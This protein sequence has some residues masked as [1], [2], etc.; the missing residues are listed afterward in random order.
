M[1]QVLDDYSKLK[2]ISPASTRIFLLS[3]GEE[4]KSPYV[5]D[6]F[7]EILDLGVMVDTIAY[8]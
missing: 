4:S 7:D 3:D 5:V 8:R 6:M 1:R 2:G